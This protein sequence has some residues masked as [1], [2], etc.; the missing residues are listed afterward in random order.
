[1]VE[2]II[3][4]IKDAYLMSITDDAIIADLLNKANLGNVKVKCN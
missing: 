1:M 4:E 3:N 2:I